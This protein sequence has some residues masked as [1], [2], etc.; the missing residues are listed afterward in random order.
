MKTL[1]LHA[2]SWRENEEGAKSFPEML[3]TCRGDGYAIA[4]TLYSQ[5]RPGC[6]VVVLN[7]ERRLRAV[8]TLIKLEAAGKTGSGMQRY[9]VYIQNLVPVDYRPEAINRC[10]V[11][12]R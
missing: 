5:I 3:R 7:K 12:V 11:A 2:P 4:S 1:V 10:G 6:P 9:N 8:G